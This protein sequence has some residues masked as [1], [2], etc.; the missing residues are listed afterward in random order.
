MV[1]AYVS[2]SGCGRC[3]LHEEESTVAGDDEVIP[4][5]ETRET[6]S[7][8]GMQVSGKPVLFLSSSSL[9]FFFFRYGIKSSGRS[10]SWLKL[11]DF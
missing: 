6:A 11:S 7:R 3:S 1:V 8:G 2:N 9:F 10:W 4:A 5:M